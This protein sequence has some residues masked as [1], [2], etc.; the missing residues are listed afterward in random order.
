MLRVCIKPTTF[1]VLPFQEKQNPYIDITYTTNTKKIFQQHL[2]LEKV[3]KNCV[4]YTVNTNEPLPDLVFIANGGVCLPRLPKPLLLLPY[5]KYQQR[6]NELPYL[7][8]IY[9][10]M[11]IKTMEFPGNSSAPFEG[12]AEIGRAHV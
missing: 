11:G 7:K 1:E 3:F 6:K 12:Q 4:T 10:D 2:A 5:M 9:K 8:Q